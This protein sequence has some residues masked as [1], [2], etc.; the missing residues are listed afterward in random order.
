MTIHKPIFTTQKPDNYLN[1]LGQIVQT[2][3]KL[4]I[5]MPD[6][7]QNFLTCAFNELYNMCYEHEKGYE[8]PQDFLDI[9][10]QIEET[11][12]TEI[13]PPRITVKTVPINRP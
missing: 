2:L 4:D 10:K 8:I 13:I 3:E 12:G 11:L 5:P 6:D 9:V 7:T 1:E